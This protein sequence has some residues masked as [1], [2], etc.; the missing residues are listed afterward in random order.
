[1]LNYIA[2]KLKGEP[3]Q[4][5]DLSCNVITPL[6]GKALAQAM[7]SN[8]RLTSLNL[9]ANKLGDEGAAALAWALG[10][11]RTV[12]RLDLSDNGV[13]VRG[14]NS[15]ASVLQNNTVRPTQPVSQSN[16]PASRNLI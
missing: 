9:A 5:V 7:I 11:Q 8:T 14:A 4:V 1:M 13:G 15:I 16:R 12:I 3:I 6:G 10:K 2:P